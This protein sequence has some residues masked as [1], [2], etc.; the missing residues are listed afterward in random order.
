MKLQLAK[1]ELCIEYLPGKSM[2]VA[3][4]LS[5]N[6]LLE[7]YNNDITFEDEICNLTTT[8]SLL[9]SFQLSKSTQEDKICL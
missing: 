7:K 1:Y 9:D 5:R 4:L 3:D 8:D 6:F 2:F